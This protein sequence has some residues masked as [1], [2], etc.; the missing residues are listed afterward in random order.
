VRL[1]ATEQAHAFKLLFRADIHQNS[2]L[3]RKPVDNICSARIKKDARQDRK[4]LFT[5]NTYD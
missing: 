5:L 3:P 4:V 1:H 2:T